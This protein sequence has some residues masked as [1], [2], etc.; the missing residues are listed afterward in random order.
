[1]PRRQR[2]LCS[3]QAAQRL[4]SG[5]ACRWH[6]TSVRLSKAATGDLQA[7]S[8]IQV[9]RQVPRQSCRGNY[10]KCNQLAATTAL[11]SVLFALFQTELTLDPALE[12][13]T[14]QERQMKAINSV[15]SIKS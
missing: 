4:R 3:L 7:G 15:Y 2:V 5:W 12:K 13:I 9:G 10:I 6:G 8:E 1:M 11:L 14:A